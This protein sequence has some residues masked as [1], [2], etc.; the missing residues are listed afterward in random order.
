MYH[1]LT[2]SPFS[3]VIGIASKQWEMEEEGSKRWEMA[4]EG[5]KRWVMKEEG[6]KQQKLEEEV[7]DEVGSS[8]HPSFSLVILG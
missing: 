2:I 1:S 3:T 7:R 6:S 4:E 5:S 8:S